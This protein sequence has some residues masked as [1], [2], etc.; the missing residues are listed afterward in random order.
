MLGTAFP[1][2][3][4]NREFELPWK[5]VLYITSI[6][7][8]AGGLLMLLI[9]DGPYRKKSGGF[10][11][12]AFGKIFS[13]K[14]WKQ[15]AIGYFGHMWELYSF[16]GFIPL[17]IELYTK[18]NNQRLDISFFKFSCNCHWEHRVRCGR[19]FVTT[20]W[21]RQSSCMV[22]IYF[23]AMLFSFPVELNFG[24]FPGAPSCC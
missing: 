19:I 24:V 7:A 2:L 8:I 23:G 21:Q 11:W 3:L 9:G 14:K 17:I 20:S 18:K 1:H 12:D 13:S 4:K 6:V 22:L 5:S 15:A 16:W 10:R